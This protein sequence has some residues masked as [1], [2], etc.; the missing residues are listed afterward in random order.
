MAGHLTRTD[1]LDHAMDIDLTS[2]GLWGSGLPHHG[3]AVELHVKGW[4]K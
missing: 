3:Q 1:L 2:V 4:E